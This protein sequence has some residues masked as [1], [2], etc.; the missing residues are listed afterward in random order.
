MAEA[1]LDA[2]TFPPTKLG[3]ALY[4]AYL[5]NREKRRR[6]TTVNMKMGGMPCLGGFRRMY[7]G[8]GCVDFI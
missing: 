6:A 3:M 4:I 7:R 1:T 5:G 8:R 2:V